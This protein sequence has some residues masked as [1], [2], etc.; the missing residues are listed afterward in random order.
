MGEDL[1]PPLN[2][3]QIFAS[4]RAFLDVLHQCTE[5]NMLSQV[6]LVSEIVEVVQIPGGEGK[7]GRERK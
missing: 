1:R 4:G 6:V 5:L 2:R 3:D 7:N